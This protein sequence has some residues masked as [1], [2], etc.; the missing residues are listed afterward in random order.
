MAIT[1]AA[2]SDR[3]ANG[4]A[5][6]L[7]RL[8]VV[9]VV[10][11]STLGWQVQARTAPPPPVGQTGDWS[12]V[13]RDEFSDGV[14][15][16]TTWYPNRWFADTCSEGAGGD[17]E[18][19]YYT[20]RP[21]NVSVS[22]GRLHLTARRERYRCGE[23]SWTGHKDYTSGWV[24]S[25]GARADDRVAP[26]FTCTVGCYIEARVKM[27]AGAVQFPAVWLLSTDRMDY[28]SRP[29]IDLAEWWDAWDRWEHHVHFDCGS[30]ALRPYHR[31]P[32]ASGGFH[33]V[34]L[35]WGENALRLYVDGAQTWEYTGCGIPQD[36]RMYIVLNL[37]IGGA[38]AAPSRSEPFPKTMLVDY[39]RA[40][41]PAASMT[42]PAATS[43]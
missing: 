12:L 27:P 5:A 11:G 36:E 40:W 4:Y 22:E 20:G 28:P 31:G 38:A 6:R 2:V 29:E 41:R 16:R 21:A 32:D 42:G 24:Q 15:D 8:L 19:Q 3:H 1:G 35:W 13:F 9:G 39:V 43:L 18:L 10:L 14:L 37:A 34:G 26:G 25:G 7:A 23:G 30:S 17:R 33:T